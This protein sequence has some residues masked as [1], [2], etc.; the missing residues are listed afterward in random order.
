MGL[1]AKGDGDSA[2][3][4]SGVG[5]VVGGAMSV[6]VG[7]GK[8]VAAGGGVGPS[9]P[10]ADNNS[11]IDARTSRSNETDF[12]VQIVVEPKMAEQILLTL[13]S[14]SSTKPLC[15]P[16]K[17]V[18]YTPLEIREK[19]PLHQTPLLSTIL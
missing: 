1:V 2:R 15:C 9:S 3:L 18:Q 4:E 10:H 6:G 5:V 13:Q 19:S 17:N 11:A 14:S 8:E 16:Q 12:M 7:S